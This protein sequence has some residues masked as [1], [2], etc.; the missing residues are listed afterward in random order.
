[1]RLMY[2]DDGG[3]GPQYHRFEDTFSVVDLYHIEVF[4]VS[5]EESRDH[6][7]GRCVPNKC[8]MCR[9]KARYRKE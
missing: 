5:F 8:K 3:L 6:R 7:N 4:G 1:M 9:W 2:P